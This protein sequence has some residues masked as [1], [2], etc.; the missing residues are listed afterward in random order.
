V[1][2]LFSSLILALVLAL[3]AQGQTLVSPYNSQYSAPSV[4][5]S[6]LTSAGPDA[7][8]LP[9]SGTTWASVKIAFG[10]VAGAPLSTL[11]Y[12]IDGGTNWLASGSG[13]PYA[14]RISA[15]TTD[16]TVFAWNTTSVLTGSSQTYE[17]PLAANVT[18]VRLIAASVGTAASSVTISGFQPYVP[19]V[20]VTATLF[21]ASQSI[22]AGSF[23]SGVIDT[24]GWSMFAV[25][26]QISGTSTVASILLRPLSNAGL[27][28]GVDL[29]YST[30]TVSNNTWRI[31]M[32]PFATSAFI[33]SD[34][35]T[36]SL[37]V[38]PRRFDMYAPLQS[39]LTAAYI[40]E[41]RR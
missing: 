19:S 6:L 23:S 32:G 34:T 39:G 16:P 8:T 26:A 29:W 27:T 1:K 31:T 5:G 11:S 9:V 22:N 7:V 25:I 10:G 20:P 41:A 13:S 14:K 35:Q 4:S 24:S 33:G 40:I 36:I 21:D 15:I 30:A 38:P 37:G 2:S 12:S 17:F 28:I 18:H 3:P